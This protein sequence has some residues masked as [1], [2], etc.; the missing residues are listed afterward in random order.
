[1]KQ[2]LLP[3]HTNSYKYLFMLL[4]HD[5]ANRYISDKSLHNVMEMCITTKIKR[6]ISQVYLRIKHGKDGSNINLTLQLKGIGSF[7]QPV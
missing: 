3:D 2:N 7:R 4:L 6:S 1:M 5:Q